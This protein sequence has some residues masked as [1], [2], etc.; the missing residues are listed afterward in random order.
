MYYIMYNIISYNVINTV[1]IDKFIY[2]YIYRHIH[3]Y[4]IL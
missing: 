1:H 4:I 2:T 3:I